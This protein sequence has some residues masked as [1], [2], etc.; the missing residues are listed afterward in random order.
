MIIRKDSQS[1]IVVKAVFISS[2]YVNIFVYNT[3]FHYIYSK[4]AINIFNFIQQFTDKNA[5]WLK[6]KEQK[7]KIGIIYNKCNCTEHYWYENKLC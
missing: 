6:F 7:D 3:N 1:F 4:K 2:F 5:C